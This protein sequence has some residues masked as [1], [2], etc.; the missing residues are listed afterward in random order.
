MKY[1]NISIKDIM[2]GVLFI[3]KTNNEKIFYQPRVYSFEIRNNFSLHYIVKKIN[4]IFGI[5]IKRIPCIN[6]MSHIFYNSDEKIY[7]LKNK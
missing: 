6:F 5:I 4:E 3:T 2:Q 7:Y 1:I